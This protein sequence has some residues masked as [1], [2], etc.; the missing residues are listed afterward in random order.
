MHTGYSTLGYPSVGAWV[1]YGLGSTNEN[2][3][4]FDHKRLT[5]PS[6]GLDQRVTN[7]TKPSKIVQGIMAYLARESAFHQS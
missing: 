2:L 1:T 7:V 5:Y 3:P 4:G 6:Q